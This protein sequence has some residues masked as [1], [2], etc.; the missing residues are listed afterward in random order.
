MENITLKTIELID[1]YFSAPEN[2]LALSLIMDECG[3]NLPFFEQAG[4]KDLERVRFA[5]IK[6][7]D[8]DIDRLT[9]IVQL[10]GIRSDSNPDLWPF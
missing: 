3:N 10:L 5:A 2:E 4:P 6:F 1:K 8:G 7:S 9:T